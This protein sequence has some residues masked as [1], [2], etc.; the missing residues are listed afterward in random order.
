MSE[1]RVQIGRADK[2]RTFVRVIHLPTGKDRIVAGLGDEDPRDVEARLI[3]ELKQE[4]EQ[5]ATAKS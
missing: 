3:E 4:I 2:G 1:F 5:N